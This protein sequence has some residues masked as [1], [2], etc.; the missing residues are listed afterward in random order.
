MP[1][2]NLL[3]VWIRGREPSCHRAPVIGTQLI[4]MGVNA[5]ICGA[6]PHV[7]IEKRAMGL[8]HLP[9]LN[10]HLGQRMVVRVEEGLREA[11]RTVRGPW[12]LDPEPVKG[13]RD[14]GSS[15]DIHG[16]TCLVLDRAEQFLFLFAQVIEQSL[17]PF[18]IE[19]YSSIG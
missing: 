6:M 15:P 17:T 18:S 19:T 14:A 4:E 1:R 10:D 5:S 8:V 3:E 9:G 13:R 2:G 11:R 12:I 7:R 16:H